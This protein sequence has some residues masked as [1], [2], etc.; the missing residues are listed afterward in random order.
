M[1]ALGL[2]LVALGVVLIVLGVV[3]LASPDLR[4]LVRDVL[5][6]GLLCLIVGLKLG[7]TKPN[8]RADSGERSP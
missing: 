4:L 1:K 5:A 6:A 2:V 8:S 7:K 3:L